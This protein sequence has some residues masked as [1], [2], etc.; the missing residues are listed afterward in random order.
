[1]EAF[2]VK[3]EMISRFVSPKKQ[4]EILQ[5]LADGSVDVVVG[6]HKLLGKSIKFKDLGLL[7]VDEE[8]RFG[9]AQKEKIKEK[10]PRVDVLTL[11]A[12]PIPR[13]L[14]MAM[15]GIR[16]MSLIEE[17]PGERHPV[18]TYVIEYDAEILQEAMER[19]INRGGQCY[20]LHN[21]V[22]T[23]EH[24]AMMIK[25]AIP[26]ARVGIAHGQMS[27]EE[28][29]S[30]WRDLLSGDIDILVCTTII[31]TGVDVP[32]CN[33]LIIEN[34]D[35]MGLAQ[36]HQIRGRVGRS[37]RRA[38]AYFT[39]TRGKELTDIAT[40]R[41]EAIR[42][43]TEF[44]SGFKIAMRDLEIRGAGSLLGNRQHGH[45]EAVGYDMY[46]KLLEEAVA[47]EKGEISEEEPEERECLIDVQIDAH[48]PEEYIISTSQRLSMYK[49]IAAIKN[50]ADAQ[51]VYDELTDRFGAPPSSVWGLIEIALL[52]NSAK[53]LGITDIVQRNGSV[54]FYSS[55]PDIKTVAI[56]NAFMKGRVTLSAA[57]RPY[58]AVKLD[59][60][61]AT[62]ETI[63]ETL[64]IMSEAKEHY[65]SNK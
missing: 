51:D 2:P 26:Q 53:A 3:V 19:E 37:S 6:T 38:Y 58:I 59:P 40:R 46:L 61:E 45:M 8:Q 32:N 15:S 55:E 41:L 42:E 31:E 43:Y 63:R 57:K 64:R 44:G 22:E 62:L 23:I 28:L 34:A 54:L 10:F 25:K 17:A 50:E 65:N 16:D 30:V 5:G 1:M 9:V 48:L 11:S 7:I 27:E 24:K 56:L 47:M 29:S 13:T 60:T 20:Y 35:R 39:F 21:N 36:L 33:T 49:R 52:R 4:K 18:Q 12:T 14:N